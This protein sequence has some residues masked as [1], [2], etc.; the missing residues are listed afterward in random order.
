M[1]IL[2]A[3]TLLCMLAACSKLT[4]ENYDKLKVGMTYEEVVAILGKPDECSD[5]M[6]ARSCRWGAEGGPSVS[7]SF[8][9]G[10]TAVF[11]AEKL[12]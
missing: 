7:V 1:R 12:N 2:L 4:T 9:G 5:A 3:C 8:L 10:K 6:L 11:S